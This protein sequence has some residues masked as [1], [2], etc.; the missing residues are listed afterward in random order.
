MDNDEISQLLRSEAS[1]Y[2]D[3]CTRYIKCMKEIKARLHIIKDIMA[4]G[5]TPENILFDTEFACLQF[6][7][8]IELIM[9]SN[10]AANQKLYKNSIKELK[11]EWRPHLILKTLESI[12][13]NFYPMPVSIDYSKLD[14]TK[15]EGLVVNPLEEGFLK[16]EDIIKVYYKCSDYL[17]AANPFA[18]PFDFQI[19]LL[20]IDWWRQI[21]FLIANHFVQ[22]V[23]SKRSLLVIV[24][25]HK[26]TNVQDVQI[27]YSRQGL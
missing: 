14:A 4:K 6:R 20:F 19:R 2:D 5:T 18:N 27:I 16:K 10:L 22:L 21:E 26:N 9:L 3:E 11:K 15:G 8:I 23:E 13:P 25:L 17:H 7:S 1:E 12:N 24:N